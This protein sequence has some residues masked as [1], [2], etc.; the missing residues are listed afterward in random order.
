MD[1]QI[2]VPAT[3]D[4]GALSDQSSELLFFRRILLVALTIFPS[5]ATTTTGDTIFVNC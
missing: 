1:N 2:Q 5:V 4:S 3:T